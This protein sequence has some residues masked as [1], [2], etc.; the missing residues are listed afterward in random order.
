MLLLY[1]LNYLHD[2]YYGTAPLKK[3]I[4]PEQGSAL[5]LFSRTHVRSRV[6][7]NTIIHKIMYQTYENLQENVRLLQTSEK[8]TVGS[9]TETG[10]SCKTKCLEHILLMVLH[11]VLNRMAFWFFFYKCSSTTSFTYISLLY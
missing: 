10:T 8:N 2:F 4:A 7:V 5:E 6:N 9:N 3:L 11:F 1:R